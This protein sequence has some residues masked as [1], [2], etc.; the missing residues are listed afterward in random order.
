MTDTKGGTQSLLEEPRH[1]SSTPGGG[2][3]GASSS[4]IMFIVIGSVVNVGRVMMKVA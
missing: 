3:V 2:N 4:C 1:D